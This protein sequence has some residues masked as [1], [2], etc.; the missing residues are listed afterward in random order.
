MSSWNAV[1]HIIII[2]NIKLDFQT[3]LIYR[4]FLYLFILIVFVKLIYWTSL[5]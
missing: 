4:L 2:F 1:F 3:H 5:N